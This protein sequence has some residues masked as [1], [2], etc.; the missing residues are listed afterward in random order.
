MTAIPCDVLTRAGVVLGSYPDLIDARHAV[1]DGAHPRWSTIVDSATHKATLSARCYQRSAHDAP[2]PQTFHDM[3]K[4]RAA[5]RK[6][7][8]P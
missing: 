8:T 7:V 1:R 4:R 2:G 3:R 6:A 5:R